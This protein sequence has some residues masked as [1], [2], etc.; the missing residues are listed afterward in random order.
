MVLDKLTI[1]VDNHDH[2]NIGNF[3]SPLLP[4]KIF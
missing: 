3:G 1:D 2:N 4:F